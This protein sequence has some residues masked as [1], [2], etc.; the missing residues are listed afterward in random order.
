M[1]RCFNPRAREGR[2]IMRR[3]S[4]SAAEFQSTRPRGARPAPP[5]ELRNNPQSFNP[6]ARE[7]RDLPRKDKNAGG[8]EFQSTR[9]RGARRRWQMCL[10]A[11]IGVSIH[12]PARGA[13]RRAV[14][15]IFARHVCFNPR[16]REG[17]DRQRMTLRE[18]WSAFQS[19]RP[20]G[21]RRPHTLMVKVS[22][23]VVSIH[24]P[25]RGAT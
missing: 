17:R 1:L 22:Q 24:A 9:P 21:A 20:R 16:A 6:R 3:G 4:S 5:R 10:N 8:S 23:T 11:V 18:S 15:H 19:T 2:D 7:G 14:L 25:A 13:T 12:A